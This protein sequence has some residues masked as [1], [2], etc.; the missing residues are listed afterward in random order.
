MTVNDVL[1]GVAALMQA[2]VEML[3]R[4]ELDSVVALSSRIRGW[5]DSFDLRCARRAAELQRQGKSS[6]AEAM[7]NRAGKRSSKEG[8]NI[9][10]RAEVGDE[11]P[12]FGEGLANGEVSAGHLDALA[13]VRRRLDDDTRRR[14]DEHQ[15]ELLEHA[16][17][18]R[19]DV[20][21]RR[22]RELAARLTPAR[23]DADELDAQRA[24]SSVKRW[25]DKV[26]GMH[27]TRLEL[28]PVRDATVWNSVNR[29]LAKL[30]RRDGNARTPW[31]QMQV[32]AFVA[33]T[34]GGVVDDPTETGPHEHAAADGSATEEPMAPGEA[35][36]PEEPASNAGAAPVEVPGRNGLRRPRHPALHH[37]HAAAPTQCCDG[38]SNDCPRSPSSST[39]A[40]SSMGCTT[41]AS[42][43]P[44]TAFP[45]PCPPCVG[46]VATPR[47][48]RP[49]WAPTAN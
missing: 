15:D 49:C 12:G 29:S 43:R 21:A 31:Q 5:H 4:A 39:S 20:F 35:V 30:R 25:V 7:F 44:K 48:F 2:D 10:Q 37:R 36:V 9:S 41:P 46:C 8:A 34:Q 42:A 22:C 3:D 26:T 40:R 13:N 11:L 27:H 33:A 1:A 14:F 18:E 6:G 45:S 24:R 38:S 28:D 19:V 17:N 47:S 16:A 23:S 32:N